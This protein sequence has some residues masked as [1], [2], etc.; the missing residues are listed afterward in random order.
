[1]LDGYVRTDSFDPGRVLDP[2]RQR[3]VAEKVTVSAA[4]ELGT[5]T[6]GKLKRAQAGYLSRVEIET[7]DGKIEKGD[8]APFPGHPKNPYSDDDLAEKL[9][10]NM[11]P[12]AGDRATEK[13]VA[14]LGS[15]DRTASVRDLTALLA[16]DG[17]ASVSRAAAE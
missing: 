1:V 14:F 5:L 16:F 2:A 7:I 13:L 3:F 4:P 12:F 6:G 9:R 11:R 8:A 10:E 17:G 15:I